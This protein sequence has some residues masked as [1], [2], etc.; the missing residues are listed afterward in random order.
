M[1]YKISDACM[2]CGSCVGSCPE[3][4]ISQGPDHYVIDAAVCKS[5]GK[6]AENCPFDAISE[7]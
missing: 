5:C 3:G 6:C 1:A 2:S 7:E 4:A